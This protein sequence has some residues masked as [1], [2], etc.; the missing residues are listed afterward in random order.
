MGLAV[1]ARDSRLASCSELRQCVM[2]E[3]TPD[4]DVEHSNVRR[5]PTA[6]PS[7]HRSPSVAV[8]I[9]GTCSDAALGRR[10]ADTLIDQDYRGSVVLMVPEGTATDGRWIRQGVERSR[11][12][13]LCPRAGGSPAQGG[14]DGG[15]D[16]HDGRRHR[17]H[18][19][20]QGG[21][22]GA[23]VSPRTRRPHH[24]PRRGSS[25]PGPLQQPALGQ[26]RDSDVVLSRAR[27]AVLSGVDVSR[28]HVHRRLVG[29]RRRRAGG[30]RVRGSRQ[31]SQSVP[32]HHQPRFRARPAGQRDAA[33][34]RHQ[35]P[36]DS[37]PRA[38][39][40]PGGPPAGA[41]DVARR[42]LGAVPV[43]SRSA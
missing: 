29:G 39:P 26:L 17:L 43:P 32:P 8:C 3:A 6:R 16:G 19:R 2:S 13:V 33:G 35:R 14:I 10:T 7:A 40:L 4:N 37:A 42:A 12:V 38:R 18:G 36:L 21:S 30:R 28:S 34:V 27:G 24:V 15:L 22:Q 9:S 1:L 41:G 23:R 5:L 25:R 20:A 11:G 31:Q